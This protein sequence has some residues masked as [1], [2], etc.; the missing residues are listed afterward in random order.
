MQV[1]D[2]TWHIFGY[3]GSKGNWGISEAW[4]SAGAWLSSPCCALGEERLGTNAGF[5]PG[6]DEGKTPPVSWLLFSRGNSIAPGRP[7]WVC[8]AKYYHDHP[9]RGEGDGSMPLPSYSPQA[10]PEALQPGRDLSCGA[11]LLRAPQAPSAPRP[12]YAWMLG[13]E[14]SQAS[15]SGVEEP[16]HLLNQLM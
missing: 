10:S 13:T 12:E 2:F 3:P 8:G 14:A 1:G 5:L 6:G 4:A 7:R 11:S 9:S 16:C 15:I